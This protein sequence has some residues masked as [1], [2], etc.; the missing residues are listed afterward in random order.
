MESELFQFRLFSHPDR[1][2]K[3]HIQGVWENASNKYDQRVTTSFPTFAPG[4]LRTILQVACLFHD[5]GKSTPWFQSYIKNLAGKYSAEERYLRRHGLISALMVFGI[6]RNLFPHDLFLAALGFMI[7]RRHHG[8]LQSF[9]DFFTLTDEEFE[10]CSKQIEKIDYQEYAQI[11]A[12][13]EFDRYV[14]KDFISQVFIEIKSGS[15]KRFRPIRALKLNCDCYFAVNLL[16]SILLDADKTDAIFHSALDLQSPILE[17]RHVDSFRQNLAQ[18]KTTDI[19]ATRNHIFQSIDSS[20]NRITNETIRIFSINT[21]TGSGKTI[22]SLYASLKLREKFNLNHIIYCLPFTSIIDQNYEVFDNICKFAGIGHQEGVLLK[23]HHLAEIRYRKNSAEEE[24]E[25]QPEQALHLIEGWES[26]IIVTTFVQFIYSLIT[27]DNASLRKFNRFSNAVIILDEVQS[28]PYAYW[29]LINKSLIKLTQLLNSYII[30][31]TATM[32]LIFSEEQAEI[33]ELIPEKQDIFKKSSRI[34]LDLTNLQS[35]NWDWASFCDYVKQTASHNSDKNIMVVVNTIR[36]ARELY[37]YLNECD[38]HHRLIYLSSHVIPVERAKRIQ[39]IKNKKSPKPLL[40]ISTQLIEAGVDID[41]EIVIRDFAPLDSIFQACGRCNREGLSKDPGIVKIISIKDAKGQ[42]PA[43]LIYDKFLLEKTMRVLAGKNLIDESDFY[44]LAQTYYSEL[45]KSASQAKSQ[46][47][48]SAMETLAYEDTEGKP[49]NA[50]MK[51]IDQ[52][53]DFSIFVEIDQTAS[54]YW[55]EYTN[56]FLTEY[57]FAKKTTLKK[58]MRR[59]NDYIINAPRNCLR[60]LPEY[61]IYHLKNSLV[62][63][64]YHPVTGFNPDI[65]LSEEHSTLFLG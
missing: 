28:I 63:Q 2:L 60:N 4:V 13:W 44:Q 45:S 33:I 35:D 41:L 31:V 43:E 8:N 5:F 26:R 32:P 61:G 59:L 52:D 48:I 37:H 27:N 58:I 49:I 46:E 55:N 53:Y 18:A 19:N 57:N 17:S 54:Q 6:L 38:L 51:L 42:K 20:I 3:D 24:I 36:C 29:S 34:K 23:H 14:Q 47:I 11:V 40:V 7:V 64:Y 65:S 62:A 9:Q 30:L 50:K 21:P 10:L 25:Y 12:P 56:L 15:L 22:A 1:L 16:Y 39:I